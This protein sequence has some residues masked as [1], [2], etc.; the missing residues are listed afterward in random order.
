MDASFSSDVFIAFMINAAVKVPTWTVAAPP[1]KT[2]AGISNGGKI[3]PP[4]KHARPVTPE[5]MLVLAA[6]LEFS[7]KR[8]FSC[9]S[10]SMRSSSSFC[11]F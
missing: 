1:N 9:L 8:I 2:A 10:F 7:S 4:T 11:S 3:T 6:V 5:T